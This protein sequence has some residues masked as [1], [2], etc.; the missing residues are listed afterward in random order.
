MNKI[1]LDDKQT[2]MDKLKKFKSDFIDGFDNLKTI[3]FDTIDND[4]KVLFTPLAKFY[5]PIGSKSYARN[6]CMDN[7]DKEIVQV[8]KIKNYI[9]LLDN[10]SWVKKFSLPTN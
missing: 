8:F 1:D 6:E 2:L 4:I 5:N 10:N 3:N 7:I 9:K